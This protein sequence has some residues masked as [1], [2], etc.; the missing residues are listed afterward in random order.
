[1]AKRLLEKV[2]R[3][4]YPTPAALIAS[5]AP[6]AAPNLIT[7]AETFNISI[8]LDGP[9]TVGLAIVPTRHSYGL[10]ERSGEF[11]VNFP[12]ADMVE[13]VDRCGTVSGRTVGKFAYAGL[14]PL[15]SSRVRPP[16]VAE[17]P[18]NLEC[19]VI[20]IS[21]TGDHDLVRGLVV[22]EHVDE[23]LL[24]ASGGIAVERLNPLAYVLG[25]YWSLGRM[26]GRHG[27][28]RKG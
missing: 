14:T 1:M 12:T 15:P 10:I 8:G 7:L 20:D 13:A 22:A 2:F 28:T 17:C 9:P 26:L 25:Q 18:V 3:P 21:K 23:D 6:G 16:I 11:T 5:V 27:F 4:V 24:D 19:T